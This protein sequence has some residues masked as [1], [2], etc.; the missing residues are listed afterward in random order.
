MIL[1]D[2][3][4]NEECFS[5]ECKMEASNNRNTEV[6]F[7]NL[8]QETE[9]LF[10]KDSSPWHRTKSVT[11]PRRW[12]QVLLAVLCLALL[13]GLTALGV[14][15]VEISKMSDSLKARNLSASLSSFAEKITMPDSLKDYNGNLSVF[16]SSVQQKLA[17]KSSMAESLDSQNRNLSDFLSSVQQKLAEKSSV[18]ESLD[19]QNRNLSDFL[20]SV[21]QKLAEKSSVAESLETQ[22]KN[23]SAFVSSVQQ[24]LAEQNLSASL[25]SVQQ[26][27]AGTERKLGELQVNH[28]DPSKTISSCRENRGCRQ[29]DSGWKNN[30]GQCYFFSSEKKNWIQS[31][32]YCISK[33]AQL[34][35]INCQQEQR[36]VST[37]IKETHW[38]GLSDLETEGQW[39]WVDQVP[40]N[41]TETQFWYTRPNGK[42]EPDNW[43]GG[44]H[45]NGEDCAAVGDESGI[46]D[47]W[48]S[49]TRPYVK[50][51]PDYW[52]GEGDPQGE[53]CGAL[54]KNDFC[55]QSGLSSIV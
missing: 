39:H 24:K 2:L 53:D 50:H 54:G 29:C 4:Q 48:F 19:S 35:I 42:H 45:P 3:D 26:K 25:S 11:A 17:E 22:N 27:L 23:L 51:E 49:H 20:S 28:S 43:T 41:A 10:S 34:V 9:D 55:G 33:G 31:R 38:I 47:K 40:L 52:T 37:S 16:L 36:F 30:Q 6:A 5:M 13:C 44:G 32:D 15:Y 21:Q 8:D 46:F 12:S 18:A 7:S 1:Y 14:Q